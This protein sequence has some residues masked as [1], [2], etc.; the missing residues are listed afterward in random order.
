MTSFVILDRDGVIN[1][2]SVEYIKSAE[3]WVALP[4]SLEAIAL[5]TSNNIDVYIATN[6]A[7]I[8]RGKLTLDA[9]ENIHKKL[10]CEVEKTGGRVVDIKYCP[11]HPDLK[12][13]CRKPNPGLL[14]EIATTYNLSLKEGCYVGDSLKDLKAAELA[15]CQGVLVLTGKGA[16]TQKLRPFHLP[17][18]SDLLAFAKDITS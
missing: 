5:L 9:L 7:G 16:E 8:A 13:W 14:E 1:Q 6:Q 11:H 4:G 15:G 2:D 12:C 18:F 10:L 17:V 3:E